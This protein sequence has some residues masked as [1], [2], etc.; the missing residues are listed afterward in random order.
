M[1]FLGFCVAILV[2]C[3]GQPG[4]DYST[5]ISTP[6]ISGPFQE[7]ELL[8]IGIT[9]QNEIIGLW[10]AINVKNNSYSKIKFDENGYVQEDIYSDLT[11]EKVASIEGLYSTQNNRMEISIINGDVHR[12]E[13]LLNGA[14]LNLKA[15]S[16]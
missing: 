11:G 2:T 8:K 10:K 6:I 15:L 1:T 3:A 4:Y 14:Q 16:K 5:E 9:Q 12:F 13:Y 7:I